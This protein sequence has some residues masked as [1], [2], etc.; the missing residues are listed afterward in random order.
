MLLQFTNTSLL[1]VVVD[2]MA[3]SLKRETSEFSQYVSKSLAATI[4]CSCFILLVNASGSPEIERTLAQ[5]R[6]T[7]CS[8]N[9][10]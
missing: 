6:E 3:D 7:A 10:Q 2:A 4:S 1:T 8:H 5:R 9:H